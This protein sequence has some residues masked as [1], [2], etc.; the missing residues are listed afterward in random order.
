MIM[1]CIYPFGACIQSKS[2][3]NARK[4]LIPRSPDPPGHGS[5]MRKCRTQVCRSGL[6]CWRSVL[7]RVLHEHELVTRCRGRAAK[8][9]RVTGRHH[10]F[11]RLYRR[12]SGPDR[13][14]VHRSI[15]WQLCFRPD[16]RRCTRWL[17]SACAFR[18]GSQQTHRPAQPEYCMSRRFLPDFDNSDRWLSR[19]A[20]ETASHCGCRLLGHRPP[21]RLRQTVKAL[22]PVNRALQKSGRIA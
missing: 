18:S 16:T 1:P 3:Q 22:P 5:C 9:H 17:V 13:N 14:G 8:L 12:R 19:A 6:Y 10:Q 2:P 21:S 20:T 15:H 7:Q 11:R 4:S